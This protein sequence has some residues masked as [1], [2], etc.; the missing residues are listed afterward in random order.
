MFRKFYRTFAPVAALGF[1]SAGLSGCNFDYGMTKFDG[2]PLAELDFNAAAPEG[3]SL[4]SPDTVLVK[5]GARFDVRVEGDTAAVEAMR[6][7]LDDDTLRIAREGRD[8]NS[9]DGTATVTVTLPRLTAMSQAGSGTIDAESL[10]GDAKIEIA[11]SGSARARN[12]EADALAIDIAGSGKV[13]GGGSTG[14]LALSIAG[15]GDVRLAD[16]KADS[17]DIS[18]AGSGDAEFASDGTVDASIAG[19][20]NVRVIGKATC[21]VNTMGSGKL[22]CASE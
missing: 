4:A 19:S 3:V 18:I 11:G 22:T 17:A 20:G 5:D 14:K 10:S 9:S 12:I 1:A 2:V 13:D 7:K 8:Y 6:F 15:S 21:N 16:L